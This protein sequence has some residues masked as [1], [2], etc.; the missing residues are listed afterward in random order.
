MVSRM[1]HS[2][3]LQFLVLP[4]HNEAKC[5]TD[6]SNPFYTQLPSPNTQIWLI[7]K[8]LPMQRRANWI[9]QLNMGSVHKCVC[10]WAFDST[11]PLCTAVCPCVCGSTMHA[12]ACVTS[13][14]CV[15]TSAA[16][17]L[18]EPTTELQ[19]VPC[20]RVHRQKHPH[21]CTHRHM[22]TGRQKC[23]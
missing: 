22:H 23:T 9:V 10:V 13:S 7:D 4:C 11:T 20:T 8:Y 3:R 19:L 5:S 6:A 17:L 12:S 15:T 21:T 18:A 14:A 16:L 1:H 2:F